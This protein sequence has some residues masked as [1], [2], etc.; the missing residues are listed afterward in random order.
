M[1]KNHGKSEILVN[2]KYLRKFIS[3]RYDDIYQFL[4]EYHKLLI[5]ASNNTPNFGYVFDDRISRIDT[6]IAELNEFVDLPF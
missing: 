4:T 5:S 3:L 1:A 2:D 6:I